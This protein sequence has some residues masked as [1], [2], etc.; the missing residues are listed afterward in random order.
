MDRRLKLQALLESLLGSRNVYF[1]PPDNLAMEYPAIV[2]SRD[3]AYS[4]SA[5]NA[6]YVREK[7]YAITVIDQDPDSEFPD[8][9]AALPKSTFSRHFESDDLNHDIYSLYF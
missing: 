4:A 3:Y 7:R 5:N 6:P 2:Y 8:K 9:I 1:Q